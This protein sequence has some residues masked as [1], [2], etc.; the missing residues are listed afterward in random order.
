M[1][2]FIDIDGKIE[3]IPF[4]L[5]KLGPDQNSSL[6]TFESN[7]LKIAMIPHWKYFIFMVICRQNN[8]FLNGLIY[9]VA[10]HVA[11]G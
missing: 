7:C 5:P 9:T 2:I 4:R 10:A 3:A 6:E 11:R 8:K 1:I